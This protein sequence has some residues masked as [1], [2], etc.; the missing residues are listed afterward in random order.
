MITLESTQDIFYLVAAIGFGWIAVFLCW[1]LYE[2][3]KLFHQANTVMTETR[4]KIGRF[5]RAVL[6]IKERLESSVNYLGMLA[7]GG[8]SLLS[9]LHMKEE[10]KE[11][12]RAKKGIVEEEEEE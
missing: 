2:I 9:F 4:E 10:K 11:R 6:S 7:E 5:E 8:K 12:R 3:A 1:A